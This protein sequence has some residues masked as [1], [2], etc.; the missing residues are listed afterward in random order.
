[1]NGFIITISLNGVMPEIEYNW[2][3]LFNFQP[4]HIIRSLKSDNIQFEQFT[5]KKFISEKLWINNDNFFIVTDGIITNIDILKNT[6]KT[7]NSESLIYL[8]SEKRTDFFS[9]FTGNFVGIF[10]NKTNNSITAFNNQTGTKKLFYYKSDT[11]SIFSTDLYTLSHT[12]DQL[13]IKKTIDVEASY[14][15]LTSGFMH[16]DYTLINEVK[17]ITAGEYGY[18][19]NKKLDIYSYYNLR[20]IKTN[21]DSEN[22]IIDKL[23]KLFKEALEIEFEFDRKYD[24]IPL[25]TLSGGL[26]SRMVALFAH[27][28]NYKN[29]QLLNFSEEG[30]ADEVIAKQ[31][32]QSYNMKLT[33]IP[34]SAKGLLAIDDVV[35]VNDGLT[36]YSGAGHAFEALRKLKFKQSGILHTGMIGDAVLGSFLSQ[37]NH[38]R[39]SVTNGLYSTRLLEKVKETLERSILKYENE[40]LYKF[41][42]RAFLGANN[43]FLYYDLTGESMSPFLYPAFLSYALSIPEKYCYKGHI[44]IK[45]IKSKHPEY[46]HFVWEAI[47]GKPTNNRLARLFFRYKR[48]VLKRLPIHTMW[49]NNMNPEQLW[50]DNDPQVKAYLDSY[51][52][53][54]IHFFEFN[55]E[56]M[57]D[58]ITHYEKGRITEKTQVLTLLS[59]YKLLF[60][61]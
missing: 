45:W 58:M 23:D 9:E 37:N 41:Y 60:E 30:Y 14:L 6:Y 4:A 10:W 7:Q 33:Q 25:T 19:S 57:T 51:Y 43:G 46:S 18:I 2:K 17:Q 8:L 59:A 31:I 11:Y 54:H 42:N 21:T 56:L 50:Y 15:L 32:A 3:S 53:T 26:D 39:P 47:G 24:L 61:K 40:V 27:N 35:K 38:V 44:Y 52:K 20:D 29:Q 22:L 48:A 36:L 12:L 55:R 34:L 13:N 5:A 49:K 28:I 1:M 16:E